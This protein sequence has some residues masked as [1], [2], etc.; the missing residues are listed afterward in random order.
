MGRWEESLQAWHKQIQLDPLN[1][2]GYIEAAHTYRLL[3]RYPEAVEFFNKSRLINPNPEN[4]SGLFSTIILWKGDINE[5]LKISEI[6]LSQN[7]PSTML[8]YYY[9]RQFDKLLVNANKYEDQF[10][11]RS[12]NL[13]RS[14]AYYLI[15]NYP[16]SRQFADSSIKEIYQK[17][18]EFPDDDRYYEALG[19][20]FAFKGEYKKAIENGE[21]C[22]KLKPIKMDA[23]Q[24]YANECDLLKIYII[25]GESDLAMDRIEYLLPIPGELS[26]SMLK[27]DPIYDRLRNLPR[28]KKILETDYK[29]KY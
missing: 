7:D 19:F 11:Y 4:K 5:A 29:T 13:N 6:N 22:I 21:K 26:V 20:A 24:G 10:E 17:L 12:K 9:N 23:W 16:Q 1:A 18:S 8:Y 3:R 28:F 25:A 15:G 27:A 2:A 14:L